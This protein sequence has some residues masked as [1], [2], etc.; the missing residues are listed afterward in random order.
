MLMESAFAVEKLGGGLLGFRKKTGNDAAKRGVPPPRKKMFAF[1]RGGGPNAA[2]VLALEGGVTASPGTGGQDKGFDLEAG[3][4]KAGGD[5]DV[6][7]PGGD[8]QQA[9]ADADEE[10]KKQK[11]NG[12][13]A[14]FKAMYA[15][16]P[17]PPLLTLITPLITP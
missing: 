1:V 15:P 11:S 16:P 10:K 8:D 14:G 13:K 2:A 17:P 7:P 9:D 5:G 3:D 6:E 4:S 12:R